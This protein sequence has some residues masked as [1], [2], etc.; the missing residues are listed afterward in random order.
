[1]FSFWV[2]IVF[3]GKSKSQDIEKNPLFEIQVFNTGFSDVM[4]NT[5]YGDIIFN[6]LMDFCITHK[7][8]H[9]T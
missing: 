7:A 9:I 4:M 1:M 3:E 6:I 8:M 5:F 2:K